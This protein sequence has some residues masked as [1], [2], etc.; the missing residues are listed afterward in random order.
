MTVG[1]KHVKLWN[2]GKGT[3][4]KINGKWD[5]MISVVYWNDKYISGSSGGS[6]YLWG[7]GAGQPTKCS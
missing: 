4:Q 6:V 3:M 1:H 2:Q 5:P 7:G